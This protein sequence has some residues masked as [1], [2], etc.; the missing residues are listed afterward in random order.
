MTPI[1]GRLTVAGVGLIGG[2]LALAA[3][4]RGLVGEVVGFGRSRKNLEVARARGIVDMV[5]DD[6][7]Q[8]VEGA[9]AIVLA[10]PVAACIDLAARFR[11]FARRG[12]VLTDVA[13]VKADLVEALE[14]CWGDTGPVVGSHP[15]AGSD[16]SGAAAAKP[17][18]FERRLCI[19][20][21]TAR[22]DPAALARMRA[23]W[24][25]VGARVEEMDAAAHDEILARVSHLPHVVAYALVAALTGMQIGGRHILDYAGTGFL[26]TTRIAGSRAE[27]WRE[28]AVAN[29]PALGRA[30][31][32]FRRALERLEALIAAE[33]AKGLQAALAEIEAVRRRLGDR[34]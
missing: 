23:L 16:E 27:V 34:T 10:A 25:G 5:A 15:I 20:T 12:T 19:L 28:I 30:L 1:F 13:S 31:G 24:E 4:A 33:D 11:P 22:T 32:E 3:R 9:D 21:P 8:A 2:S 17:A 26:D 29:A 14:R 7:A 6:A 18:L